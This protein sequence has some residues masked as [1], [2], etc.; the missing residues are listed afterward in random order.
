MKAFYSF[1]IFILF[2]QL[3]FADI[4]H[5]RLQ[6]IAVFPIADANYQNVEDAWWQMREV[7]TKE[8]RFFVASKRFMVNRGVFQPR[9]EL[10]PA[11]III[12]GK[13][14]DADA[15]VVSW[16]SERKFIFK[17]HDAVNGYALWES[18]GQFHPA[19]SINDQLVRVST[20]MI[21][22]FVK[23]LPYH[24][25]TLKDDQTG[26]VLFDVDE[27]KI[28]RVNLGTK[29]KLAPDDNVQW[30]RVTGDTSKP[31]FNNDP[32]IE[33]IAEGRVYKQSA[34]FIE[35]EL[36]RLT[37]PE[38]LK[39]DSLVRIPKE[40]ARANM[41]TSVEERDSN[42]SLEY[43]SAEMK[44]PEEFNKNHNSTASALGFIGNMALFVLLAF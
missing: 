44:K 26:K 40:L 42:L 9:K 31:F 2:A 36:D 18:E 6:K 4:D 13:I 1:L 16:V 41:A 29:L 21:Q 23:A 27:K 22:D 43:L 35:V 20:Q 33:V 19:I 24:G 28:V 30:I 8:Q 39:S 7:L 11:D 3:L 15:I 14:L 38:E 5:K 10:K 32:K 17:V 37:D 34:D 25:Y 12:L